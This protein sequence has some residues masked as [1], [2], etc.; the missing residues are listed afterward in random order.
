MKTF[1]EEISEQIYLKE[2]ERL[3]ECCLVFPG[4]RAA[5]FFTK[6]LSVHL[7]KPTWAPAF[8][9][10]SDLLILFTGYR[11]SDPFR[12]VFMLYQVYKSVVKEQ[13]GFDEFYSFGEV[14]LNDFNDIDKNLVNAES[15]FK[16]MASLKS[17]DENFDYLTEEQV[18]LIRTFWE[19]FHTEEKSEEKEKFL[20]IWEKLWPLY[21]QLI[22]ELKMS[23]SVYEGMMYRKVSE[24][25]D[26]GELPDISYR[27]IYFVG[28]NA[29]TKS[30]KQVLDYLKNLGIAEFFWDYDVS[31]VSDKENEA[32][33][34]LR[35][36]LLKFPE[37]GSRPE[38]DFLLK[39]EKDIEIISAPTDPGQVKLMSHL[40]TEIKS[41]GWYKENNTAVVLADE[42]LLSQVMHSIPEEFAD[43]NITM[44][45]PVKSTPV[46]S[47]VESLL[48]LQKNCRIRDKQA[49]FYYKDVLRLTEHQYI[50]FLHLEELENVKNTILAENHI[51]MNFDSYRDGKLVQLIF[52]MVNGPVMIS[53]YLK[54][55]IYELYIS[56]STE[57]GK[58][59]F[60]DLQKE[61]LYYVYL[62]VNRFRDMLVSQEPEMQV[63]T[64]LKIFRK[65]VRSLNIPF[66]GEPLKGLQVMG[67]LE[68]RA[69]DFENL[70]VLS[71]NEGVFPS[72]GIIHSVIPFNLR[73]GF[74][75]PVFEHQ[76]RIFA[77]YFY[78][79]FQRTRRI[80]FIYNMKTEGSKTGEMSRFLYQLKYLMNI[81]VK[82]RTLSV[83]VG[84]QAQRVIKIEKTDKEL[85]KL[86]KYFLPGEK[87]LS[88]S[89]LNTYM[90][91][92]LKFY[93]RYV[94]G[95][96]EPEEVT[97]EVDPRVFGNLLHIT[98]YDLYKDF[99]NKSVPM[100]GFENIL[101]DRNRL[102]AAID[103]SI[104]K[105]WFKKESEG[106]IEGKYLIAREVLLKYIIQILKTDMKLAPV[107]VGD[108]E[109]KYMRRIDSLPEGEGQP[110]RIG[111]MIDRTDQVKGDYRII[112]Y[113]TGSVEKKFR[114]IESL[115][116]RGS[117]ARNSPAFQTILYCW[118]FENT[119]QNIKPALYDIKDMSSADFSPFFILDKEVLNYHDVKQEFEE[120][121]EFLISEIY[122]NNVPFQQVEE[123]AICKNCPYTGLCK[124]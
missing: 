39:E 94:A 119:G 91:C 45:Y 13:T 53:D 3:N 10:I 47:L 121:L 118:L 52:K 72:S 105:G 55:I 84:Q 123:P 1:L 87:Y 109:K 76:D 97:E 64:Y 41:Q 74:G 102:T 110:V 46:F 60:M 117:K 124:K 24:M 95:L 11:L 23:K 42:H 58:S 4:R 70:I 92:S 86:N 25:I 7:E 73:R 77:Y 61:Y 49:F 79:F 59:G 108:L 85:S 28:F 82:E 65:L 18:A 100:S 67:V 81:P 12:L 8:L 54:E 32:G 122:D 30:E 88:P 103:G 44:G 2:G 19:H 35:E 36:N 20:G 38:P 71:M 62:A 50:K 6:Y 96:K 43:I 33:F 31:Y 93:F 66:T 37:P 21:S 40:L 29:L 120:N 17:L 56:N 99:E 80:R 112:D 15:L 116:E 26:T 68:T 101:K 34:F 111:G 5:L 63:S 106:A 90:D 22:E 27:K 115:F 57:D 89:A 113:K 16:N 75:L 104:R 78:R 14:L 69:L 114:S 48:E 98:M 83:I 107:N 9:T 51:Y